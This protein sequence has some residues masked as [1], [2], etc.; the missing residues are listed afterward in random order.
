MAGSLARTVSIWRWA[1]WTFTLLWRSDPGAYHDL[2]LDA[3]IQGSPIL[4]LVSK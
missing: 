2:L 3:Q 4:S 1:G